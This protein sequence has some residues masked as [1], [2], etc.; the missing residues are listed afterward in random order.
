MF[1]LNGCFSSNGVHTLELLDKI[2]V[3]FIVAYKQPG[4]LQQLLQIMKSTL[5]L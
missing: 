2:A 5:I 1:E 3:L 4:A